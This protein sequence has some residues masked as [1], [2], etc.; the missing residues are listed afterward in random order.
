MKKL[1]LLLTTVLLTAVCAIAQNRTIHGT[2]VE[3][4]TGDPAVGAT[5]MPIGGGN[6]TATDIDGNFTLS[7]PSTV[8]KLKVSY[9]GYQ[10]QTVPATNGVKVELVSVDNALDEVIVVAYGTAKKSA[11]T[12]S[13]SV[14][15]ADQ[16]ENRLVTDA[17]TALAGN[18]SGVQVL[19]T[20][21]QPGSAPTVRIRGIG[22]INGSSSPLYVVDG[23][24]FDGDI[25]TLN[26]MDIE[27]M[28]VL[29]DAA[30]AAL[31][32]ARGANGVILITT[33]R[34]KTGDAVIS[35]DARWGSNSR[36]IDGY[37]TIKDPAMYTEMAY[38]ALKN[39]YLYHNEGYDDQ[40]AHNAANNALANAF[41]EGYQFYT[42][43]NGQQIV[44][45]NGKLNPA[46]KLGMVHGNNYV[47][48]DDWTKG[49]LCNGLRQEYNLSITGGSD[50]FNFYGSVG[51]L[52]N[53]GIIQNSNYDRLS[54]RIAAEYQAKKWLKLGTSIAYNHVSMNSP[55]GQED[56]DQS[57]ANAF[58][59]IDYIAPIYP[60]YVRDAAGNILM[61]QAEGKPIYDYGD[62]RNFAGSHRNYMSGG[63][64]ASQII[65]DKSELLMDVL[66]AKW[67]ATITPIE[68]LN[69][70]GTV[71]YFLDNTR[72]HFLLSK[73][74]GSST[75]VERGGA[76]NMTY[77]RLRGLNLQALA[78]YRRTF[79]NHHGDI[80][81]GAESYERD[82]ESLSA[83]G[84]TLYDPYNWSVNNTLNNTNRTGSGGSVGYATRGF[85]GRINYDYDS[86]YFAS[87]SFRRDGSSRFAPKHRWGNF[88]SVSAAWDVKKEAFMQPYTWLDLLKLKASFGQQGNDNLYPGLTYNYYYTDIYGVTGSDSW[89]DG[90]LVQ[91]G[92]PELTWETSNAFNAG[93]DFSFLQGRIDG[94]FEYYLR[95]THNMLYNKPVAPSNGFSSIP[96]NVGS[97]RNSGIEFEI[98][99]RPVVT[100]DITLEINVNGTY[101]KNKIIS[102]HPDL[103]GE[104][105]SGIRILKEGSSLYNYY[106]VKYAGVNP[107]NG[108]PMFWAREVTNAA[109]VEANPDI[110]PIYGKEYKTENF[111]TASDTNLCETGNLLPTFYGGFGSTL[112]A[113][114]FDF[115]FQFAF[116][117]G[118]RTYDDGYLK[119]MHSG[120]SSDLGT[121]WH[122]DALDT[123][124]PENPNA[125][126]PK[127]DSQATYDL[128]AQSTTFGLVSS[129]YLSLNNVTVG[130]TFPAK[131][132]K[133]L[134]I[135]S[136][137]VYAAGDNLAIITARK[138]LDP[139]RSFTAAATGGYS[140]TRNISGGLKVVF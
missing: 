95:Q 124:T 18:V 123:W 129:D 85:F 96:M 122:Q 28:T 24:P 92:N 77:S 34:G 90:N 68:N 5:V 58:Y 72:G 84:Y 22:S 71:G 98:T 15:K 26:T 16:I 25:A 139:R 114:G 11:Y 44:G 111:D 43:P 132:M 6:G 93:I 97:M 3:A 30:A 91:K 32:G 107:D 137:R 70:T 19:Q 115:S 109:E 94:T 108:A 17:V 62:G 42:I 140:T 39:G 113:Y 116:Q 41:G 60:L 51:Y 63:N 61:D 105:I 81:I 76:A 20:N 82:N 21:G 57:A 23:M 104:M 45:S 130:Y 12:G 33:K 83:L 50:R 136:L 27:S 9:V 55:D 14:V 53:E 80:M 59:Y 29:K 4:G 112:T 79:G 67:Y 47:I 78:T 54:A 110:E 13:A 133:K 103:G 31:Y 102:L 56:G 128:A 10:E 66:D 69:I 35:L 64:P 125:K 99:G 89:S 121:N 131:W 40:M 8:S 127:L 46:A 88:F 86:K 138:G 101:N 87:V 7:I 120:S 117:L 135:T 134:G 74:Y 1:F 36:Q 48:P 73:Y 65:Y 119:L 2:V 49:T 38:S 100:K 52:G 106:M 37:R 126:Y 75:V 118:G